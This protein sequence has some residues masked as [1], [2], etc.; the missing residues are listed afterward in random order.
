MNNS[1]NEGVISLLSTFMDRYEG[2]KDLKPEMS[3]VSRV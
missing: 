1:N 3:L 2:K